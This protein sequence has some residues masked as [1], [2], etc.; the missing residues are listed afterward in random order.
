MK[1]CLISFCPDRT[2][3]DEVVGCVVEFATNHTVD[4]ESIRCA[5]PDG[6][7]RVAFSVP[8]NFDYEEAEEDLMGLLHDQFPRMRIPILVCNPHE[9]IQLKAWNRHS[10]SVTAVREEYELREL[11]FSNERLA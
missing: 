3:E 1:K 9:S 2:Y 5:E 6:T 4:D 10:H 11:R 8:Q 7:F